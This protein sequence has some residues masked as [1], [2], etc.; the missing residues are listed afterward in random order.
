MNLTA[1]RVAACLS[2]L[3]FAALALQLWLSLQLGIGSGQGAWRGVMMYLGYF[4]VLTNMLVAVVAIRAARTSDG[5]LD[6]AWRGAAVASIVMV[7]LAYHFLLRRIWDPQGAQW[8]ADM[9]LHYAVPVATL[10]WWLALPPRRP[11]PASLPLRWLLWP[12]GYSVY[13]LLRGRL[14]GLYPYYFIDVEALG[15]RQVLL[16]MAGLSLIFVIMAYLVWGL[17]RWRQPAAG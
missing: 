5:G 13:V 9:A 1:R 3:T 10:G 11:L 6:H 16:N 15:L 8:V 7:G 14:T 4:T 2:A 12:V 17:A